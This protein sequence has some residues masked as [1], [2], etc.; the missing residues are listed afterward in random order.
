VPEKFFKKL[1]RTEIRQHTPNPSDEDVTFTRAVL[2]MTEDTDW[3]AGR[4]PRREKSTLRV[5]R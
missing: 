1:S 4:I 2:A 5:D 3:N